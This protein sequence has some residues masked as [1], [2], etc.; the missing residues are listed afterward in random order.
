M[1]VQFTRRAHVGE[2]YRLQ[3]KCKLLMM[4]SSH[5]TNYVMSMRIPTLVDEDH[6][7]R[8]GVAAL[9]ALNS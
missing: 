4:G 7:I 1:I 2:R 9:L 8:R 6:W 5:S 3:G